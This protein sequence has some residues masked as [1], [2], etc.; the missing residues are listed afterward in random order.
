MTLILVPY[1]HYQTLPLE[2]AISDIHCDSNVLSLSLSLVSFIGYVL[3]LKIVGCFRSDLHH[4]NS[5][6]Y[7]C[8][9]AK[10]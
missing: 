7:F 3:L 5:T 2:V 6:I 9:I 4:N 10:L 8:N 1:L